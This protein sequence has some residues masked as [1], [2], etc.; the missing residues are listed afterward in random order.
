MLW[1]IRIGL[2]PRRPKKI[3]ASRPSRKAT[4]RAPRSKG[5]A[6]EEGWSLG[7][8]VLKG[9]SEVREQETGRRGD[10]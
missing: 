2:T 4:L 10:R 3:T 8:W 1:K 6:G 7:M 9:A 5:L